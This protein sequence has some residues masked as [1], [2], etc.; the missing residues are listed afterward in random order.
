MWPRK[1]QGLGQDPNGNKQ[2]S[3]GPAWLE[4]TQTQA[5]APQLDRMT[6]VLL[7]LAFQNFPRATQTAEE[8]MVPRRFSPW[9]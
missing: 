3:R 9:H 8:D 7:G 6:S 5:P 1:L 4:K 2:P